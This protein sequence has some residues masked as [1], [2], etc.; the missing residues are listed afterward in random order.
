MCGIWTGSGVV[1]FWGG[2]GRN[3]LWEPVVVGAVQD[4]LSCDGWKVKLAVGASADAAGLG[5]AGLKGGHL[6][7]FIWGVRVRSK[8]VLKLV[9]NP[10]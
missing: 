7:V 2:R 1:F 6:G 10:G 4:V 8:F 5:R 9:E 3:V